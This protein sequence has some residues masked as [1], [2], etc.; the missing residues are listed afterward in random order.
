MLRPAFPSITMR[1]QALDDMEEMHTKRSNAG[2]IH[3]DEEET[4]RKEEQVKLYYTA[5][6]QLHSSL[7]N[8]PGDAG[9]TSI[10]FICNSSAISC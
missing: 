8:A 5:A 3:D 9:D 1:P 10:T 2:A 7:G 4:R 6:V